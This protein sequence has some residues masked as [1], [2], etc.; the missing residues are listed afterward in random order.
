MSLLFAWDGTEVQ[1]IKWAWCCCNIVVIVI[2]WMYMD[3]RCMLAMVIIINIFLMENLRRGEVF[4]DTVKYLKTPCLFGKKIFSC[5]LCYQILNKNA[6]KMWARQS[7]ICRTET[8][9]LFVMWNMCFGCLIIYSN[10]RVL[11]YGIIIH[12]VM[13]FIITVNFSEIKTTMFIYTQDF[14]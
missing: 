11:F 12:H 14:I 3:S 13:K 7:V 6:W 10:S 1:T 2:M 4:E 9:V 5:C 8:F